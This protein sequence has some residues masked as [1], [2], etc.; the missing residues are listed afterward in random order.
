VEKCPKKEKYLRHDINETIIDGFA[1][2]NPSFGLPAQ[3]M[4]DS[5]IEYHEKQARRKREENNIE[6]QE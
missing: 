4:K 6:P 5:L 1:M 2:A 3:H